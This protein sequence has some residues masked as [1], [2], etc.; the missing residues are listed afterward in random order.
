MDSAIA[1]NLS[2]RVEEAIKKVRPPVV[3]I[4]VLL[5]AVEIDVKSRISTVRRHPNVFWLFIFL[6]VLQVLGNE[7]D[8]LDGPTFDPVDF[9]NKKFPDERSL[10]GL[11]K[12]IGSYDAE[13]KQ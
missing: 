8:E 9:I 2:P 3:H 12:A 1:Q 4:G 6:L 5:V 10:D 11:D 7:I 13:I